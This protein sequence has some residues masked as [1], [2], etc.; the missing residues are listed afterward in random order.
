MSACLRCVASL[1]LTDCVALLSLAASPVKAAWSAAMLVRAVLIRA[2]CCCFRLV[3]SVHAALAKATESG[4]G[5][6]TLR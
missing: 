5:L 6:R 3:A 4:S 2:A 1:R